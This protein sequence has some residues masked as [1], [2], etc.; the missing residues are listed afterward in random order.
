MQ[1]RKIEFTQ[2]TSRLDLHPGGFF[3]NETELFEFHFLVLD[4]LASFGIKFHDQHLLGH[5]L[6]VLGRGV[7]MTRACSRFQLDFVASAFACH[8]GSP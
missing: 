8:G 4:M 1:D 2:Q 3:K 5:R 7:E 6:L